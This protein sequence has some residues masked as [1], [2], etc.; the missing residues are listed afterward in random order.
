VVL[1]GALASLARGIEAKDPY[2]RGHSERVR[3]YAE[4]IAV[5]LRLPASL[6]ARIAVGAALHDVGKIGVPDD[7]LRRDGPLSEEERLKVLEHTVVGERILAPLL[8]GQSTILAIVRW[9][10]EKLDGSGYPDGLRGDRIPLAVRIVSVADAFDAMTTSRPYRR[11]RSAA[12]AVGELMRCA[13]TQFDA[14]CVW[15]LLQVLRRWGRLAAVHVP[16]GRQVR[17]GCA[18]GSS[19][20]DRPC[21]PRLLGH[22]AARDPRAPPA[23]RRWAPARASAE[24]A[25]ILPAPWRA[26]ELGWIAWSQHP[27]SLP[28]RRERRS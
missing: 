5:E 3:R 7:L 11:A 23:T 2:T 15:A 10:H 13:G 6:V 9:H 4:A 26:P 28:C 12:A 17:V 27:T 16:G 20:N 14:R 25:R 1:E 8:K 18:S 22:G 21:L 24:G 19:P